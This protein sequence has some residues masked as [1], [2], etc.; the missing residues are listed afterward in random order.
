MRQNFNSGQE[1]VFD[2]FNSMQSRLER[3]MLDRIIYQILNKKTDSFFQDSF[4]VLFQSST[5]VTVKA[6][7]GLQSV[8]TT[9]KDPDNKPLVLD[10]DASKTLNTPDSS[11]DRI[12]IICIKYNRYN[13]DTE[14]R[15]FKDEFTDAI[16]SQSFVVSTDW[17]ADV[18]YVAGT[19]AASPTIPATPSGYLKIAEIL[20]HASTGIG[21]QSDIT[22]KRSLLPFASS[23][24]AIGGND[25]DAVVG[26]IL[27]A[28]V[29][30][31]DL[32]SA[33]DNASDGWKILILRGE[34]INTTPIVNN[35]NIEL[36][37]KRAVTF[38]KGTATIG[39]EVAGNDCKISGY[40][41][42]SFNSS[43]DFG[44][45]IDATAYRTY[46]EAPRFNDCDTSINDLGIDTFVNV[47]FTE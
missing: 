11:Y 47:E 25:Y 8:V 32:K 45:Q 37:F 16:S 21:S 3:G 6:G 46:I 29:T 42:L 23:T 14:S 22:D 38:T 26:D 39:L 17:K 13:V 43:G 1:I 10:T 7:L 35:N 24:S 28:G 2:D 31:S 15:K 30:H 19:P 12:D 41:A 36:V 33:L 34:T 9:N 5:S 40:R 27:Q 20:V 18:N 44:I 4:K